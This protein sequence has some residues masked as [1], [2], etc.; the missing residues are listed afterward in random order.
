MG[1]YLSCMTMNMKRNLI[2]RGRVIIWIL[3]DTVTI[4]IM[5]FL[6]LG[7]YGERQMLA[8]MSRADLVTYYIIILMI[9]LLATSH[10]GGYM[11][12]DIQRGVLNQFLIKPISYLLYFQWREM[13]F[14]VLSGVVAITLFTALHLA[15]PEY[16]LLP[17]SWTHFA[18]FLFFLVCAR[19][20]SYSLQAVIGLGTF[21][22]G[23]ITGL[24]Q[25]R[26]LLE[27][28]F[29]GEFA[30]LTFFPAIL[31]RIAF[32]LP[33]QYLYFIPAQVY[34]G[35][36]SGMELLTQGLAAVGWALCFV[37]TIHWI[38]KRGV[39]HYEGGGV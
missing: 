18:A 19:L 5:P 25:L 35:R 12:L 27:K 7:I 26:F 3:V 17:A 34:L 38:W 11:K 30:P 24:A 8:G 39:R 36:I 10:V 9:G 4:T 37:L 6:W 22:L 13:G 32:V 29:G 23:E 31:Q 16:V 20:I 1:K 15:V 14:R 21:W 33:F 2:F 28:T